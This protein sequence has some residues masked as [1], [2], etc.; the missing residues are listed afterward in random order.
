TSKPHNFILRTLMFAADVRRDH[1]ALP[2]SRILTDSGYSRTAADVFLYSKSAFIR[3]HPRPVTR[4]PRLLLQRR[5]HVCLEQR[6]AGTRVGREFRV[7]LAG[8]EPWVHLLRQFDHLAQ[9]FGRRTR[10]D[11]ETGLFQTLHV[12]VVDLVAVA[13]PFVD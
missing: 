1:A 11:D 12:V 3:V 5:F 2:P 13:M 10:R 7:E 4:S 8:D 6:M 9:L